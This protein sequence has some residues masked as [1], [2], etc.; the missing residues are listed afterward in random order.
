MDALRRFGIVLSALLFLTLNCSA[1]ATEKVFIDS[2]MVM[3]FTEQ[4]IGAK[5]RTCR[6]N[7]QI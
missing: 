3:L 6:Q 2:D 5:V 1:A 7:Q 4:T